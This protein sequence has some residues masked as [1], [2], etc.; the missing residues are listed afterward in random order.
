MYHFC[1]PSTGQNEMH[2]LNLTAKRT[3]NV[4]HM[5]RW[6]NLAL[7]AA[8]Y[9]VS[10]FAGT[11]QRV[12]TAHWNW[13]SNQFLL[14]MCVWMFEYTRN[15]RTHTLPDW[16]LKLSFYRCPFSLTISL[17][18]NFLSFSLCFSFSFI[19][20]CLGASCHFQFVLSLVTTGL[21]QGVSTT[22]LVEMQ[23]T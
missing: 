3:I 15:H 2:G 14:G 23:V 7:S 6:W 22:E 16:T 20:C 1:P 4:E 21:V 12:S 5:G 8:T 9:H 17:F 18:E 19:C 10:L 11:L 13:C